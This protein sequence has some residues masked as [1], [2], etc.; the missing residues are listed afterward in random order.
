MKK[1]SVA[2]A[3]LLGMACQDKGEH[4]S[5]ALQVEKPNE[6]IVGTW[7]LVYGEIREEDSIQVKDLSQALFIKIINEDHFAFFNQPKDGGK[8]FYG[9][10]GSYTLNG[11]KYTE[12]LD[13][14]AVEALRGHKFPFDI[15]LKGD[16]LIQSGVEDVPEANIKRHIVEKYIKIDT[17]KKRQE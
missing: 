5:Q 10:G 17:T 11:N 13:Y 4:T 3:V 14:V 16:T 1:I 12:V 15:A 9:G 8:G 7:K 6:S 2:L